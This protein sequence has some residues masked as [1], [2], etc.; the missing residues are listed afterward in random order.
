M[1]L[2]PRDSIE[3]RRVGRIV[4]F[5]FGLEPSKRLSTPCVSS[6]VIADRTKLR[7][8]LCQAERIAHLL[9]GGRG[10]FRA[11]WIFN[12]SR[13]PQLLRN[14]ALWTSR[15]DPEASTARHPAACLSCV[16][17][18]LISLYWTRFQRFQAARCKLQTF[19]FTI[20]ACSML[21]A[22]NRGRAGSGGAVTTCHLNVKKNRVGD[23][24]LVHV[25]KPLRCFCVVEVTSISAFKAFT[26]AAAL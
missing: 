26:L 16:L 10:V 6:L 18:Q 14:M 4:S 23:V 9:V 21:Q 22:D 3:R 25:E 19:L 2:L 24:G 15:P 7:L 13:V 12:F 17:L 5:S 20:P 8:F 1:L 11:R